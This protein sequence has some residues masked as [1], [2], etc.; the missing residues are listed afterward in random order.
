VID[1]FKRLTQSPELPLIRWPLTCLAVFATGA[2]GFALPRFGSRLSLVLLPSGFAVAAVCRWGRWMWTA[3][4]A[5]GMAIELANR[6]T[7]LVSVGVGAGLAA[8]AAAVSW[9]LE[10]GGFDGSF[11]RARDVPMFVLASG[12]GMTLAPTL[13]YLGFFASGDANVHYEA[14]RW[15]RW[16]ANVTAGV[17][18]VAPAL[19]A[20]NRASLCPLFERR[21]ELAVWLAGVLACCA[22]ILLIPADVAR[23]VVALSSL[24]LV[25]MGTIRLGLV[26]SAAGSALLSAMTAASFLFAAGAFGN[27]PELQGL[28]ITWT[29]VAALNF[30]CLSLTALLAQRDAAAEAKLQAEH[31]YAQIFEGSPQPIWVYDRKSLRFLMI[32]EAALRQ[33]GWSREEILSMSVAALSPPGEPQT[34]P[35]DDEGHAAGTAAEP[36]ET[37]HLTRDGR[38]LEVEVWTRAIEIGSQPAELVFALDV[39]ARRAFGRAL[40]DAIAGEQR[41]IGQEMHDGLGQELTGLALSARALANRAARERDAI[42]DDLDQ[43]AALATSCIQDARLIV[44]GLSPLTDTDGNLDTALTMLAQRSSLSG[45]PVRFHARHE[46]PLRLDL[47]VR[48]HLYRIAQEAVQNALKHAGASGIDIELSS[49]EGSV[50][51]AILDDGRGLPAETPADVGLGMRT[52]R[53]RSSAIGGRLQVGKRP[54]GGN[55]VVCEVPQN[56][57]WG[58]DALAIAGSG[59]A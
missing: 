44:Q 45:T 5:G 17:L 28:V 7:L 39:S 30:V 16:W 33:Y 20:V 51:L 41:R 15:L 35:F 38:I 18:L 22:A 36:F 49:R 40:M 59:P 32:N 4:F 42:A 1:A 34:A 27:L 10:R 9:L 56:R 8:A 25:V 13:G 43:L 6:Q 46:A 3:V 21:W 12:L 31:R 50:R 57:T 23:P 48:N 24:V 58:G 29:Y 37:R 11:R 47:K 14:V 53:F 54:G 26:I 52:M 2:L 19:I 55:S